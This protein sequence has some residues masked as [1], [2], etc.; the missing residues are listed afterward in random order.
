M[1]TRRSVTAR[2]SS[3]SRRSF[4]E[5]S[6]SSSLLHVTTVARYEGYCVSCSRRINEGDDI[7][8][9]AGDWMHADCA[10]VEQTDLL[11]TPACSSCFMV[12]V[13]ECL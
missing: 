11:P 2:R 12:H 5:A 8:C 4:P 3:S 1:S 6:A 7:T 13:G 10:E 9:V